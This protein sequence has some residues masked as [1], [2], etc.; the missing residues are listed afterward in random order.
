MEIDTGSPTR[1]QDGPVEQLE[2]S[3]NDRL[4]SSSPEPS[5]GVNPRHSTTL[6]DGL[7]TAGSRRLSAPSLDYSGDELGPYSDFSD[8]PP[9][10]LVQQSGALAS[11][12]MRKQRQPNRHQTPYAAPLAQQQHQP[13]TLR[14]ASQASGFQAGPHEQERV[15]W[16][17]YL[18]YLKSKGGVK[19]W[20]RTWVV[21]RPKN[22]AFYKNDEVR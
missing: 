17:G 14:N 2:R 4:A 20:K 1:H 5:D 6:R 12:K 22:L 7:R 16:H 13:T 10:S 21:L 19:Q 3:D 9:Q 11:F 18:L 8:T 15:I